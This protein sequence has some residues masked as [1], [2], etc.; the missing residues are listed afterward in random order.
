MTRASIGC[1]NFSIPHHCAPGMPQLGFSLGLLP[2]SCCLVSYLLKRKE[3]RLDTSTTL[4][5]HLLVHLIQEG[6]SSTLRQHGRNHGDARKH[7]THG[8]INQCATMHQ[9]TTHCRVFIHESH[10]RCFSLSNADVSPLS[11]DNAAGVIHS[12]VSW[13]CATTSLSVSV[14]QTSD[15][16]SPV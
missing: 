1:T 14:N 15:H 8:P 16:R 2:F 3:T 10:P 13:Q 5:H 7:E 9:Q 6:S 4:V 11:P 12:P